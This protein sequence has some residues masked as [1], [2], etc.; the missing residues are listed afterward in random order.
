MKLILCRH[1]LAV[2][3]EDYI[4]KDID[5][6]LRPLVEKGRTRSKEAAKFLREHIENIDLIVSSPFVRAMQTAEILQNIL[7]S[8]EIVESIEL[9]PSAPP[10]AFAQWL[11]HHA[12]TALTIAAVGHEPQLSVFAT[13]CLSGGTNSFVDLKKSGMICLEVESFE[14]LGPKSANLKWVVQPK[15][16]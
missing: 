10:Q 11:H 13:W 3:R 6:S 2:E 14:E 15:L 12:K 4:T 8:S 16:F 1:G 5:D 9:V 7:Q